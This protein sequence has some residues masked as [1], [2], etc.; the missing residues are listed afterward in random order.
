MTSDPS[1]G[2]DFDWLIIVVVVRELRF[3]SLRDATLFFPKECQFFPGWSA[4]QALYREDMFNDMQQRLAGTRCSLVWSSKRYYQEAID[5]CKQRYGK[6]ITE[7]MCSKPGK[8]VFLINSPGGLRGALNRLI[9]AAAATCRRG[10]SAAA[11]A[12]TQAQSAGGRLWFAADK[13]RRYL[14]GDSG[15]MLHTP[16]PPRVSGKRLKVYRQ[17]FAQYE[18][19]MSERQEPFIDFEEQLQQEAFDQAT[20]EIRDLLSSN[21]DSRW[22]AEVETVV[23]RAKADKGNLRNEVIFTGSQFEQFGIVPE[24]FT[25]VEQLVQ[26]FVQETGFSP[27]PGSG[28]DPVSEFFFFS[29]LELE[30][31][32]RFGVRAQLFRDC[33]LRCESVDIEGIDAAPTDQHWQRATEWFKD[34]TARRE[35]YL[36]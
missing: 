28:R 17:A 1:L 8:I 2:K 16:R 35:M 5:Q 15:I 12:T 6:D 25:D 26:A 24:A 21:A 14:L 23:D 22:R 9:R 13:A 33:T 19:E 30:G 20:A 10:G 36:V 11:I 29:A 34:V 7:R 18:T 32:R 4:I 31:L 27:R 3:E